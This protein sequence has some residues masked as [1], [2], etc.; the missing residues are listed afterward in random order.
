[1]LKS[2]NKPVPKKKSINRST[3]ATQCR[4]EQIKSQVFEI[5][6]QV[7]STAKNIVDETKAKGGAA[8]YRGTE[9]VGIKKRLLNVRT[10][11][12]RLYEN[13]CKKMMQHDIIGLTKAA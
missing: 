13:Y 10:A 7:K 6:V 4:C 1:M 9:F 12:F 5:N 3:G 2:W 8:L 11:V